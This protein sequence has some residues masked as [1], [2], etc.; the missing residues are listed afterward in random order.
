M[1][2]IVARS[3]RKCLFVTF[4]LVLR[5]PTWF[6]LG[7]IRVFKPFDYL[8]LVYPGT[9]KDL[10]G[11][12]P[13]WLAKSR[14]FRSKPQVGGVITKGSGGRGLVLV[15]PD[16]VKAFIKDPQIGRKTI[17]NLDRIRQ[18]VGA[19]S[20]AIAGQLPGIM[21]RHRINLE[22]PFVVGNSGTVFCVMETVGRVMSLHGLM[23][24]K[25]KTA[26]VGVGFTGRLVLEALKNDGHDIY[27]VDIKIS[28]RGVLVGEEGIAALKTADMVIVLTPKGSD[29]L[30]YVGYLKPGCIVI[31]DTHPKI[32]QR[33]E[34]VHFYKV[35]MG[36]KGVKF[37][38]RLPGY[39]SNWIPGCT[40]EAIY[41]A[42]T[43]NFNHT[44]QA[45]FNRIA[46]ELGFYAHLVVEE[47]TAPSS[48]PPPHEYIVPISIGW[49]PRHAGN[50]PALSWL[51]LP[52]CR[53]VVSGA[54][55]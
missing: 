40:V 53:S 49:R 13:R 25:F 2:K 43:G 5:W 15:V 21:S 23:A 24:G 27:G 14:L 54:C 35:A 28:H 19:K 30:P 1:I 6:L 48:T 31:D 32:T 50:R 47:D 17:K 41:S 12:C 3:A 45:E 39:R 37:L 11:Y 10:D 4:S 38:P 8:F 36:M 55:P 34:E 52:V 16:T 51:P 42:A 29:F 22:N 33:P 44:P 18:L 9:D 20:I 26:L 46:R 7:L